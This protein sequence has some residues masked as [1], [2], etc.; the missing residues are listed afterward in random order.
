MVSYGSLNEKIVSENMIPIN[1]SRINNGVSILY[2]L[3]R[4]K[5]NKI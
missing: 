1:I 4:D 2:T 5:F 3:N